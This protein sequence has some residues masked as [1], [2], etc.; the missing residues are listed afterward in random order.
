MNIF[1][2][3]PPVSG[4]RG[5]FVKE[6]R[7]EQRLTSFQSSMIPI[8][9]PSIAALLQKNGH[10]VRVLDCAVANIT[11]E[12]VLLE[13]EK[14]KP[15]IIIVNV[16]TVTYYDDIGAAKKIK[17]RFPDV[18]LA[19]IGNHV[20]S[21][22]DT[23]LKESSFDSI[24]LGEPEFTALELAGRLSSGI[25][26]KDL[27]GIATKN[28]EGIII[29]GK[30]GFIE[31]L[32]D[33]PFPARD[34]MDNKKYVLPITNEPYTL[35]IPSRGCPHDCIFCTSSKYYGKKLRLRSPENIID[36]VKEV[37]NKYGINNI[38]MWA[39]TFTLNREFVVKICKLLIRE[40][41]GVRWMCNSRVDTVDPEM[42]KLMKESGCIGVSYGVESG[43]QKIL[44]NIKKRVTLEQIEN[45]IKWAQEAG[46]E[47]MAHVI[48][49]LPGE[50]K[51]TIKETVNFL[52]R[53]SPDYVQIYCATPFPGTEF[54]EICKN[55]N[56]LI[57]DGWDRFEVNAAVISTPQIGPEELYEARR[58]AYIK[59]YLNPKYIWKRIRRIRSMKD[60]VF[61]IRQSLY[62]VS[63][64]K[65]LD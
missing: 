5:P 13:I 31:N 25:D 59:F 27:S 57:T 33:L 24:I 62:F 20:T 55:K 34:L 30:T 6:G 15:S 54:Y 48:F 12:T 26:I 22:P 7:C 10:K 46:M 42:L 52:I 61:F 43:N 21:L 40:K 53:T 16:S 2:L 23:T 51:E 60:L 50:T 39:D 64:S 8:S 49:G 11:P 45:A 14:Y 29:N 37:K 41:T 3:N 36:E 28:N 18:H 35:V 47:A 4:K 1:I 17:L 38:V 58:N 63:F 44:D 9:L 56:C 65:T 32:D 19:A